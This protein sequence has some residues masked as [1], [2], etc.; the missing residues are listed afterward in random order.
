[1]TRVPLSSAAGITPGWL[2]EVLLQHGSLAGASVTD[3]AVESASNTLLSAIATLR[4]T[5]APAVPAGA[6]RHL[7]L[8]M[9]KDDAERHPLFARKEVTFYRTIAPAMTDPPVPRC[10]DAMFDDVTGRFHVLLEDLS[11]T[12]R[13]LTTWPLPPDFEACEHIVDAW[14]RFH[15]GWWRDPRLGNGIGEAFDA[16]A[17]A[18]YVA[19]EF[20]RFVDSLGDRLSSERRERCERMVAAAPRI[21]IR[22]WAGGSLTLSHGDAHFWNVLYPKEG[23]TGGVNIIDWDNWQPAPAARDLAYMMAVHWYPERRRR[24]ERDLLLRY[25]RKLE[26]HGVAAYDMDALWRDYRLAVIQSIR[27]PLA[28]AAAGLPPVIWWGH[29]ERIMLAY[30]D[31]DCEELMSEF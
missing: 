11:E 7:F 17:Y 18:A 29:L 16:D 30:E 21:A 14:A 24:F 15:A 10:Y 27:T 2:T 9:S 20:S 1:M 3:V 28:Q 22:Q 5:Y 8:K 23:M 19:T 12:H 31:L 26:A 6:P 4:V 13:V 25:Q